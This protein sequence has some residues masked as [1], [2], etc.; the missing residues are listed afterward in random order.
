MLSYQDVWSIVNRWGIEMRK[1][2]LVN[3]N[4]LVYGIIQSRSGCLSVIVRQWPLGSRRHIHRL[5]RLHRFLKNPAVE[6]APVFRNIT[7]VIWQYRPGGRRTKLV[8]IAIDWTKVRQFSTLWAAMPRRKRALPLAFGVYHHQ[9]LRHSQNMLERCMCTLVSS[10]LPQDVR[11]LFLGDAG[12]GRTEFIRWLQQ[13]RFAFVLRLRPETHITYRGETFPLG[14]L[15][16]VEGAPILLSAVEY[17]GEKP[18]TVNIV[19][20][21]K[22]DKVW[23][24]GTTFGDAQQTV[25]WYKKRFWIEEMFRD[26]KSRLG[27]RRA[28]LKDEHRLSR[29]LL[30][31]QIAYVVLCLIGLHTPKRWHAYLSS[32]DRLSFVCLPLGALDLFAQPRHRKVWHRHVWPA[33]AFESG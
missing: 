16:T 27:L 3:L 25:A 22:G 8:P 28:F 11:P 2:R 13:M 14:D 24:L 20:S 31:Y 1:T 12:F 10:L 6:V 7:A 4:L 17:R 21:R 9:R 32:R 18:V 15:D 30:A 23:F 33:L 26:F 19:I 5:K 29:L